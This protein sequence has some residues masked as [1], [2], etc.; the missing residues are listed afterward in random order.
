MKVV[1]PKYKNMKY[2]FQQK[3]QFIKWF[4]VKVGWRNQYCGV[5]QCEY[6]GVTYYFLDNEYYFGRDGLY[7]FY[8][9]AERFAFFDRAVM[10]FIKEI[11]W[12]PDII[13][14]NDWQTGM[15]PVLHKF[16]YI[17]DP[18]YSNIKTIFSIHNLLF[19]GTYSPEILPELFGYD[20][21]PY[22]NGSLKI[23]RG[24]SFIKGGINYSDQVTTVSRSYAE[25]IKSSEYGEKLDGLLR[26]RSCYLK[27]I[28]NGI[29]YAEY[30]PSTDSHIYRNYNK[31]CLDNKLENKL[32]LQRQLGLPQR[33]DVPMIGLVSRLTHQKGCDLIINII[34]RLLQKDIQFVIL[35]TGDYLYE[36]TFRNLQYRYPDKVSANIRFDDGLA[37]MIYA[38]ADMFMMPSLFEPCGLGQLIALRYGTVPIVRETG[39][40]KDTVVPYNQYNGVGNGF[41]FKNYSSNDLMYV[42]EYAL[43]LFR[44]K[45]VWRHI[46]EQS[47]DSD[48]SWDK[49]AREYA[50]LYE[51]VK[52]RH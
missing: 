33:A 5:S 44:N 43:E 8:D 14:C 26:S 38:S 19:Q 11:N 21:E 7:G 22:Y 30:N 29:D 25:E 16:E 24:V 6:N 3:L 34:D 42:T 51:G 49:A 1:L 35:G 52:N 27:G 39:G 10:K 4:T 12:Q 47:M 9:D 46:V 50:W 32:M 28:V 15:V 31:K 40:L 41:G 37:H 23:D 48:N 20:L 2:E 13:N 45:G 18:F 36:E 17:R